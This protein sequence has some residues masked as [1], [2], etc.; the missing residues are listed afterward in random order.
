M[1]LTLQVPDRHV[2]LSGVVGGMDLLRIVRV[3]RS[4]VLRG[5]DLETGESDDRFHDVLEGR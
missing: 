4:K 3:R 2:Q 5:A 1:S